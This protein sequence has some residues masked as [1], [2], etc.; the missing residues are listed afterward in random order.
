MQCEKQFQAIK[1][2]QP[3]KRVLQLDSSGKYCKITKEMNDQYQQ[4]MNYVFLLKDLSDFQKPSV[5]INKVI[6]I[7]QDTCRL[8]E[9]FLLLKHNYRKLF[10]TALV[11][12][13]IVL[14]LS[15]ASIHA[16]LEI[17]NMETIEEYAKRIYKYASEA[18]CDNV[19]LVKSFLSSCVSHTMHRF[20]RGFKRQVKF[21]NYELRTFAV[22]C[23]SLLV[24][25]TDVDLTKQIFS[26]MCKVFN[27]EFTDDSVSQSILS[28]QAL[29]QL[30]LEDATEIKKICQETFNDT[31]KAEQ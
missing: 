12:R 13:L 7:G 28:L 21:I 17:L 1:T 24:N 10:D 9:M 27:S 8:S 11:F 25:S 29:I 31:D 14:D 16:I 20:T 4:I 18:A 30:R 23:F 6:T 19:P 26:L 5:I 2:L 3:E 22:C 15:W